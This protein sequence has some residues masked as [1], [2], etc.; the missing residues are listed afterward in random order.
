[1][2]SWKSAILYYLAGYIIATGGGFGM[3]YIVSET[4]VWIFTMT[5]MPVLFIILCYRYFSHV[6]YVSDRYLDGEVVRLTILWLVLS[7]VLDVIVYVFITPLLYGYPFNWTF[8][9]DH[10]PLIWCNYAGVLFIT[11]IGK[12]IYH[13][14]RKNLTAIS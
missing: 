10:S 5:L 4:A 12:L 2:K 9:K 14:K 8:F 3:Y 1:M 6:G 13:L 11:A 7:F